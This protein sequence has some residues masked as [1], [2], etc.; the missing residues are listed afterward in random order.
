M[1]LRIWFSALLALSV[2]ACDCGDPPPADAGNPE[3]D[4][5]APPDAGPPGDAGPGQRTADPARTDND[6]RDTDCDGLSDEFEFGTLWPGDQRTDPENPDSDGDG[7]PD[8]VEAGRTSSVDP[9]CAN[10]AGD[11]DPATRTDPTRSDSDGD[12]LSDGAEDLDADGSYARGVETDPRNPDSDGDGLCDGPLDVPGVCTG[13]DPE[14]VPG[15]LDT[16]GD[17]VPD[18]LDLTPDDPDADDD[19]LCDGFN[20]VV[21]VCLSGE[22]LDGDGVRDPD[23]SDPLLIDTDC[24]GLVDGE[25]FGGFT[26]ERDV[27]TDPAQGDSDGDGLPDGLEVGITTAPDSA[28]LGFL[29]D[30][31]PTTTT[32]PLDGDSDDDLIPDGAED[33]NQNGA[34][35]V[36][37]LDPNNGDDG[38]GDPTTQAACAADGLVPV[39]QAFL[40]TPDLQLVTPRRGA[41]AFEEVVSVSGAA[42]LLGQ[43]AFDDDNTVAAFVLT[44]APRGADAVAEEAALRGVVDGVA[45]VDTPITASFTTWDGYPAVR[46]TYHLAAGADLKAQANALLVGL[47]AGATGALTTTTDVAAPAGIDV[48]FE[49]IRRS[50]QTLVILLALI[51]TDVTGEAARFF[52]SDLADG[53]SIGQYSDRIAVQCDRFT[54]EGFAPLDILWAVDNSISMDNEQAQ[55]SD[56]AAALAARL[57]GAA[58]DWRVAMVSSGFYAPRTGN[59]CFNT[60]CAD[61]YNSQCRPW[62][63]DIAQFSAWFDVGDAAGIGAGGPCNVVDERIIR[64]AQMLLTDPGVGGATTYMP[65]AANDA[66]RLRANVNLA[67]ILMGDA[68]DQEY[69]NAQLPGGIDDYEAFFR[70]LPV[71]SITF[72][73]ILCPDGS[74]G[75]AQRNPHVAT[76]LVNRFG[77]VLGSLS[78]P[79]EIQPTVDAIIDNAVAV[80]SPYNLTKDAITSTIKVAL[81]TGST[82]GAC[83]TDDVPRS[84]ANGFDYSA[85]TRTIQFFGDCRPSEAAAGA[86]M[87]VS[88][89]TWV[90]A[91]PDPDPNAD[92]CSICATCDGVERCDL[93]QC[94]C[95]CD[96][97]LTCAEGYAWDNDACDCVCDVGAL[98]CP[99]THVP[100]VDVCG[101]VCAPNC[102]DTCADT[103]VC[104][105]SLCEC[106]PLF[107]G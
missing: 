7:V 99:A 19:G 54:T 26:G 25:G 11:A 2:L 81:A 64:G 23:E 71:Q 4:G 93:E 37:E 34:V 29:P 75:E 72:G 100:D 32:N 17:G 27:G 66:N 105:T 35:D 97:E 65:P 5:G 31:D 69:T 94:A 90:D 33:A 8:G 74:C 45:A 38:A 101:C 70:A 58:I 62:S 52:W 86:S 104:Q 36:G 51:P 77:G 47:A 53:S 55:V 46:G 67:V 61:E 91:S 57:D 18:V 84:R 44:Q 92:G 103:D 79:E 68:D 6:Q 49:V 21:G 107:S 95:V 10:F 83:N 78:A 73:G 9:L 20:E 88:Y 98:S 42:G 43:T 106:Q 39:D 59:G 16:D 14:P 50:D 13:G 76:N 1:P 30:T 96:Q 85:A 56:G 89:R 28:C 63:T 22:D 60:S 12:G 41:P 40:F 24:D 80:A 82:V 102:G 15:G 48:T 87:S 3:L